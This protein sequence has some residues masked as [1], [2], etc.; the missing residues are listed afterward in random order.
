LLGRAEIT[1]EQR[2]DS[3]RVIV[4]ESERL[5]R[6][7]NQIL[8]FSKIERGAVAY[9][10]EQGDVAPVV[11]GIVDDYRDYLEHA[12]FCVE[13][14]IASTAPAVRFDSAALSQAVVNLLDNAVKYSGDSRKIAVRLAAQNG[15]VTFE[16][17]DH[18]I[19]IPAGEQPKVFDRF[20]R[21]ANESGKG[22]Y[23]LG[24]FLVRHIMEAHGGRAEV[25]SEPGRG[26]RFRLVFPVV[27]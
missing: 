26:S 25:E 2:T 27:T 15:S 6:L 7:V 8:T 11:G 10:F 5:S 20:Y 14:A 12:G 19:G 21:V 3:Y 23:G 1:A 18:G 16:V 17:E 9:N 22:G 24:L 13:R 4:R